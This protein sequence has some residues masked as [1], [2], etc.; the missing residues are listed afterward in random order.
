MQKST[1]KNCIKYENTILEYLIPSSDLFKSLCISEDKTK[2][3][4]ISF[5]RSFIWLYATD[6]YIS[7]IYT[8]TSKTY[9]DII[10]SDKILILLL[11]MCL[12]NIIYLVAVMFKKPYMNI[13]KTY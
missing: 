10:K 1:N 13:L 5:I 4:V 8:T 7:H 9:H 6:I 12:I 11:T 2:L 3:F